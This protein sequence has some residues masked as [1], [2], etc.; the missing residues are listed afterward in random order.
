[1]TKPNRKT[2]ERLRAGLRCFRPLFKAADD[3]IVLGI[4]KKADIKKVLRRNKSATPKPAGR[5]RLLN[6]G[7]NQ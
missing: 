2:Q 5:G 4:P 7:A 3:R 6:W 1:M